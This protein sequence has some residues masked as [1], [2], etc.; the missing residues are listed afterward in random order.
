LNSTIDNNYSSYLPSSSVNYIS[1]QYATNNLNL[2]NN[3]NQINNNDTIIRESVVPTNITTYSSPNSNYIID[4]NDSL[5]LRDTD[6]GYVN[7][8]YQ[9]HDLNASQYIMDN[10]NTD[11]GEIINDNEILNDN[12][13]CIK[14]F[15]AKEDFQINI[16]VNDI[17]T[18]TSFS[19]NYIF[20][21]NLNTNAEGF[22]PIYYIERLDG[23]IVFFRCREAMECASV[24]DEIFLLRDSSSTEKYPGYNITKG[25]QGTFYINNLDP[26]FWIMK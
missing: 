22:F 6:V 24:N 12:Y 20:G 16:Q 19:G 5:P 15:K 25:I 13:L 26:I 9:N 3:V 10:T 1:S 18:L 21:K 2:T 11:I 17:I 4:N 7:S 23:N 14:E 8:E